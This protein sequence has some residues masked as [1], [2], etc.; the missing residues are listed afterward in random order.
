M[1]SIVL[2][3]AFFFAVSVQAQTPLVDRLGTVQKKGTR[4]L[5]GATA[6]RSGR[7]HADHCPSRGQDRNW[8][9][10][11]RCQRWPLPQDSEM[12]TYGRIGPAKW[13]RFTSVQ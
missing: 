7:E 2:L 5:F 8:R 3:T 13:R 4:G 12:S 6:S 10:S 1:R 11:V 9:G